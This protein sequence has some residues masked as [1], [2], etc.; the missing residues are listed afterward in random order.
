[1]DHFA[2]NVTPFNP[3]AIRRHLIAN[4][5]E[6]SQAKMRCDSAAVLLAVSIAKR[7]VAYCPSINDVMRDPE[8]ML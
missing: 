7:A 8:A 5:L 4:G 1:M 6:P 3:E 2:I